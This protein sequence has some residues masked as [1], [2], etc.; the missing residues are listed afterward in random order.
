MT[1]DRTTIDLAHPKG[2]PHQ[3]DPNGQMSN[4]R[5]GDGECL[6]EIR[7]DVKTLAF[8]RDPLQTPCLS[9]LEFDLGITPADNLSE[10][11][12][13]ELL[14]PVRYPRATTGNDT[15]L[16]ALLDKAFGV[17]TLFVYNNSPD[18]PAVDPAIFLDQNFQMQAG[19]DNA[20]AGRSDAFAG[21]IGGYLLVNGD[22]FQQR[23]AYFGAGQ[24]WAG[25][26]NAV[27]GYFEEM[28]IEPIV[29]EIPAD[30]DNW[31]FV[32]FVG[33]AATFNPDGSLDTIAQAFL[34][35]EQ[36]KRMENIILKFKGLYVWFGVIVTF[37]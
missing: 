31:P 11:D 5:D 24:I 33:G 15:D 18:G 10:A 4:F 20:F 22:V 19:A 29:Y 36:K 25:N 8:I 17:G 7:T 35:A 9:D 26:A 3:P 27:A 16:Q 23:P 32:P 2:P 34:P 1:F 12:R 6:T 21:R 14:R 37:T 28:L 13:R 30:P